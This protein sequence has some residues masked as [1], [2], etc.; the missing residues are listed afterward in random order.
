MNI[1]RDWIKEYISSD[2]VRKILD[3]AYFKGYS[4]KQYPTEEDI[5]DYIERVDDI[6]L[7]YLDNGHIIAWFLD[8]YNTVNRGDEVLFDITENRFLTE[9]EAKKISIE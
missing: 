3:K 6:T 8:I 7:G 5:G 9:D 1:E 4:T 2:Q